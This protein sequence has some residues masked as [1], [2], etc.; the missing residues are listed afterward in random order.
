MSAIAS[1]IKL[2]KSAPEGLRAAAANGSTYDYLNGKG[3]EV[4]EYR[5]SGYVLATLLPYLQE[6]RQIDLMKSEYDELAS[7]ITS[8]TGATHFIFTRY[9][10]TAFL[11]RLESKLFSKD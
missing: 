10:R 7:I 6:K 1:F 11:D 3:S 5:W 8:A 2:P 4:A 9:Q